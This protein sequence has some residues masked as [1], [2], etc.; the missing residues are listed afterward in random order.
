MNTGDL[1]G[2]LEEAERVLG[3]AGMSQGDGGDS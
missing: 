3:Y 1:P 2:G